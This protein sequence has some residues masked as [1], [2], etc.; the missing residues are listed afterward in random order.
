MPPVSQR[1]AQ[2]LH[3]LLR[4]HRM[5]PPPRRWDR[6]SSIESEELGGEISWSV[7]GARPCAPLTGTPLCES[8]DVMSHPCT[9]TCESCRNAS[10]GCLQPETGEHFGERRGP[11]FIGASNWTLWGVYPGYATSYRTALLQDMG[12]GAWS[13]ALPSLRLLVDGVVMSADRVWGGESTSG[14]PWR[15]LHRRSG[16][17][18][19]T[20]MKSLPRDYAAGAAVM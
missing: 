9:G 19:T 8:P 18:G 4:P 15:E 11:C 10:R 3:S 12:P 7:R 13:C 1:F 14:I 20:A 16:L 17:Q 2:T 6:L 5:L